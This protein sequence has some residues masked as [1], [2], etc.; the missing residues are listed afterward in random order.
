MIT[1]L[2]KTALHLILIIVFSCSLFHCAPLRG[3][4]RGAPIYGYRIVNV[5][6]HDPKAF[7]QGLIFEDGVLYEGTGLYGKSELRKT[8]LETGK[9]LKSLRLPAQYF[10]EGITIWK[11]EIIQLT[12]REKKGFVYGKETFDLAREF[13]YPTE[14]WGLTHDDKNLIMSDGS[15]YLYFLNPQ[16]FKQT[17]RIEVIDNGFPVAN[18]NELEYVRGKILANVWLTN[19]IAIISPDTGAVEAWLDLSA[20][21]HTLRLSKGNVLNGV[22]YDSEHDRLFVT[23]KF[24]P[25]LFEIQIV[26]AR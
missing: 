26:P 14:G 16:S 25:E 11:K 23:G 18:L 6:P 21:T 10:G 19:R 22:A 1:D 5:Y 9:I 7:T 4:V 12:W 15:S 24:W 17:G 3:T 8:E 2:K 20:L 13:S